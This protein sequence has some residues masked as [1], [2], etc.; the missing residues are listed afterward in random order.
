MIQEYE[1]SLTGKEREILKSQIA[2]TK[3][4]LTKKIKSVILLILL[5]I[6]LGTLIFYF[7]KLWSLIIFGLTTFF[8][9]W[10]LYYE[11]L[12]IIRI[13]KFLKEKERVIATGIVKVCEINIDRFIK[14]NGFED[15]GNHFI[16]EYNNRLTLIGGQDFFGV[17]NL[18][19]KNEKIEIMD[20]KK[21]AIYYEEV[22]KSGKII[23]PYYTLKNGISDKILDSEIWM[24][25]TNQKSISGKLEDLDE[26][27]HES[28]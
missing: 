17:K 12:E 19:N 9:I 20:S 11:I 24:K 10:H 2:T 5:V 28:I 1:R 16:T 3:S 25:L 7:Q 27:L 18:K 13:P 26:F 8:I 15:E 4:L 21:T 14:I 23:N 6:G 22:K